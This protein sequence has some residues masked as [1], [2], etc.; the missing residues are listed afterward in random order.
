MTALGVALSHFFGRAAFW[1]LLGLMAL[2]VLVIHA[3]WL[4]RQGVNG[5]TGEP[6]ERYYALRGW[7][8]P[9]R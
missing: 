5:W 9:Q 2:A 3:W 4:P 6:K 8:P 1:L 7:P